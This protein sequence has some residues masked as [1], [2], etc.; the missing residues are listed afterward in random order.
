MGVKRVF[1][2]KARRREGNRQ[3][4]RMIPF[5]FSSCL[6]VFVVSFRA[7]AR[8]SEVIA[9]SIDQTELDH[10]FLKRFHGIPAAERAA[11]KLPNRRTAAP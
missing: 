1:T 5:S 9:D 11:V 2:A 4:I 7:R 10:A 8:L 3:M 6:R